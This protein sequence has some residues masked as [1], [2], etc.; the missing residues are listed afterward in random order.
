MLEV[1]QEKR[2]ADAD[3]PQVVHA[4]Q[5]SRFLPGS[6]EGRRE[7][8]GE[9]GHDGRDQK[10]FDQ[11]ERHRATKTAPDSWAYH[12][13]N[14]RRSVCFANGGIPV[15]TPADQ[16][17]DDATQVYPIYSRHGGVCPAAMLDGHVQMFKNGE[18]QRRNFAANWLTYYAYY[19]YP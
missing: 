6:G 1:A 5:H 9:D 7:E 8:S 16:D 10:D 15:P 2:R 4:L 12:R 17:T 19:N 13:I 14:I 3:V 11:R 18:M